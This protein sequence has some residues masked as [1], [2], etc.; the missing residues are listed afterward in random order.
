MSEKLLGVSDIAEA[1]GVRYSTIKYYTEEGLLQYTTNDRGRNRFYD[2]K[3]T[4]ETLS[5]IA[6]CKA[7][8]VKVADLV[9]RQKKGITRN[10]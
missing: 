7:K 8:G 3:E 9:G 2:I 1:V 10:G 4:K 5:K 6:F